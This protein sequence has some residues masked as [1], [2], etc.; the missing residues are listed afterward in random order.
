M[1]TSLGENWNTFF[2]ELERFEIGF[3]DLL[4]EEDC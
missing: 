4:P 1:V 3:Q 2:E